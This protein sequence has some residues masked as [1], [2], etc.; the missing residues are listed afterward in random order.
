MFIHSFW[1]RLIQTKMERQSVTK[2]T[3]VEK[4]LAGAYRETLMEHHGLVVRS[5]FSVRHDSHFKLCPEVSN[6]NIH[7]S[8]C[9]QEVP[10]AKRATYETGPARRSARIS[11]QVSGRAEFLEGQNHSRDVEVPGSPRTLS[12]GSTYF[13]PG[14]GIVAARFLLIILQG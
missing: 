6:N 9:R 14:E 4:C 8:G 13:S 2:S 5:V 1:R 10:D 7:L 3:T 12:D 11:H